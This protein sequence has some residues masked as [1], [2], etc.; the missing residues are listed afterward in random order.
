LGAGITVALPGRAPLLREAELPPGKLIRLV[1]PCEFA[2]EIG[3]YPLTVSIRDARGGLLARQD[4][5]FVVAPRFPAGKSDD[6]FGIS[7]NHVTPEARLRVG[8]VWTRG[9][10]PAWASSEPAPGKFGPGRALAKPVEKQLYTIIDMTRPPRWVKTRNGL[11]ADPESARRFARRTAETVGPVAGA[12][13][14]QNEPDLTLTRGGATREDAALRLAELFRVFHPEIA[15]TGKPLLLNVSGE[16]FAFAREVF[17]YAADS[18]DGLALHPYTFPR[19][20]GPQAGYCSSPEDGNV[21][22]Q[23]REGRE[24]IRAY[25]GNRELWIGELGWGLD[26]AAAPDSEWA[27]RHAAFLAR[28]FLLSRTLPELKRI[29]W[30]TGL[31]CLEGGRYEYGIWR[32]MNGVRPLPAAAAFAWLA[33]IMNRPEEVGIRVDGEIKAVSWKSGGRCWLAVWRPEGEDGSEPV[34]PGA[35]AVHNLFGSRVAGAFTPGEKP[36]YIEIDSPETE[37]K[38]LGALERRNPLAI[39]VAPTDDCTLAVSVRNNLSTEWRGDIRAGAGE[40]HS[41]V[42]APREMRELRVSLPGPLS[43]KGGEIRLAARSGGAE[44]VVPVAVPPMINVVPLGSR[45]W[46]T[47]PFSSLNPQIVIS[48]RNQIQPPDPFIRWTGPEDLSAKVFLAW[49]SGG[50]YL[51]A[52]VTDDKFEQPFEG[53]DIWRGDSMQFAFDAGN[54]ARSRSGY[55]NNDSEFGTA[56]GRGLWRWQAPAGKSTGPAAALEGIVSREGD[57]ICY[58]IR[59]PWSEL[60]PFGPRPGGI[61]GFSAVFHDRDDGVANCFAA[62]SPGLSPFKNPALFRKIRLIGTSPRR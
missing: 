14:L 17:R 10:A 38:I 23:L 41:L 60:A 18:I 43:A 8:S 7:T 19:Y 9:N 53:E 29:I 40:P 33:S 16:G 59:I 32:N 11:P 20:I 54:D 48:E 21:L 61:A 36:Y 27:E 2:G 25:G 46:K 24:L 6:F 30:F 3:Y 12:F 15:K 34:D 52:E 4:A 31:G 35:A 57:K 55:D 22:G 44:L 56:F 39:H 49:D 51:L 42:L 62:V 26:Y 47:E 45:D 28:T 5:P 13:E 50:F 58:R 37:A 1:I